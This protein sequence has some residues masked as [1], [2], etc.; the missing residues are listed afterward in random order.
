M[1]NAPMNITSK[2][3]K[4]IKAERKMA[5]ILAIYIGIFLFSISFFI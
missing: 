1:R 4:L 5:F 2:L 3:V